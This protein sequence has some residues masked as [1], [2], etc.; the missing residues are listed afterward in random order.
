MPTRHV[1][2]RTVAEGYLH[3][4]AE[5]G[6]DYFFANAGTD[7]PPIIEALARASLGH[8]VRSPQAIAVPHEHVAVS[9]AHGYYLVTGRPQAVMLIGRAHV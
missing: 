8:G 3:L 2:V 7:F 5:R 1:A 9:M 6:V 4:L